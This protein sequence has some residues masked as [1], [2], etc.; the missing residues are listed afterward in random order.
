[1]LGEGPPEAQVAWREGVRYV[2]RLERSSAVT[3]AVPSAGDHWE[4]RL[5]GPGR[6]S[7]VAGGAAVVL[8][9]GVQV[10]V[11]AVGLGALEVQRALGAPGAVLA[12]EFSGVVSGVGPGAPGRLGAAVLAYCRSPLGTVV[13]TPAQ[14]VQSKPAGLSFEEAAGMPGAL[15]GAGHALLLLLEAWEAGQVTDDNGAPHGPR[16]AVVVSCGDSADGWAVVQALDCAGL[17]VVMT[18]EGN[19]GRS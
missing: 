19:P 10:R 16:R 6:L 7:L 12:S 18:G 2:P 8:A 5:A 17:V 1:M 14:R 3:L 15:L 11:E 4:L 9:G 13:V